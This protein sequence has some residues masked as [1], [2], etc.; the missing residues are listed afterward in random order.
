MMKSTD[1]ESSPSLPH[2]LKGLL[3]DQGELISGLIRE[4]V[5]LVIDSSSCS[6]IQS[7]LIP[8]FFLR[9]E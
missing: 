7:K 8:F 6:S 3:K 5:A 1:G 2:L 4:N 9:G